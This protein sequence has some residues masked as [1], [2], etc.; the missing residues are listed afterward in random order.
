MCPDTF[1]PAS[2]LIS[3]FKGVLEEGIA[4]C[5]HRI[6]LLLGVAEWFNREGCHLQDCC[7]PYME[8]LWEVPDDDEVYVASFMNI[9]PGIRPMEDDP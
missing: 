1:T 6:K 8:P 5:D 7:G 4:V 2:Y 9:T 3:L